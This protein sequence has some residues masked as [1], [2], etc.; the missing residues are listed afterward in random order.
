[1]SLPWLCLSCGHTRF[2]V[3]NNQRFP[4]LGNKCHVV[5][6]VRCG[7]R[8]FGRVRYVDESSAKSAVVV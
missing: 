8:W 7:W 5:K 1:M 3:F 2:V 4:P 6:C